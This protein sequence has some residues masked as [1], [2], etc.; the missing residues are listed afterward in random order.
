MEDQQSDVGQAQTRRLRKG[1]KALV[2]RFSVSERA[3]V[4]CCGMTVAQGAALEALAEGG[5]RLG[6]LGRRLGIAPSTLTRNLVRLLETGLVAR[7]ED[8]EDR[9]SARVELTRDGRRVAERMEAIEDAFAA[10]ILRRLPPERRER[11]LEGLA[12]LLEAVRAETEACC[13]GAY[14]HLVEGVASCRSSKQGIQEV[15]S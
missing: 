8:R 7:V 12:D 3:D 6:E 11:A 10:A 13:P 2:R 15:C 9:R 4:Q 5:M 14:D 1:F